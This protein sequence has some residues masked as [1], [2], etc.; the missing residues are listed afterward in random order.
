MVYITGD[1]HGDY[2]RV[3]G[4]CYKNNTSKNDIMI[5]LGDAGINYYLDNKD[6][7]LKNHL[8]ELPITLFCIHGNHEERPYNIAGYKSKVFNNGIVYYEEKYPNIL[9]AKDGE[10]YNFN[11]FYTLVIG[12]AYSVDKYYRLA[13]GYNWYES[14]NQ[15]KKLKMMLE[16]L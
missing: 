12:G 13:L 14:N 8:K 10:V 9:F 11:G 16:K 7:T 3:F 2:D 15:M 5:V 1:K 6:Y 4:F